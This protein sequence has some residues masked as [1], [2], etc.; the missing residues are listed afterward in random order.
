LSTGSSCSRT[1]MFH[2]FVGGGGGAGGN[3]SLILFS[4]SCTNGS[5]VMI[6]SHS[7][8]LLCIQRHVGVC[9]HRPMASKDTIMAN[10]E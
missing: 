2:P 4:A 6:M 10:N 7:F 5:D 8:P 3:Y 9:V 1:C